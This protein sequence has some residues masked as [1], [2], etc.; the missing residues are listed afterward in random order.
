MSICDSFQEMS[1]HYWP[2]EVDG[3]QEYGKVMVKKISQEKRGD[4]IL[5]KFVVDEKKQQASSLLN[6]KTAFTVTQF[7]FLVW[8]EHETPPIT[9]SLIELVD[10][11]N[12]VQM[13]SGNRPMIVMCK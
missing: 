10:N 13:G 6:V 2:A 11:V 1:A 8:P 9:S 3:P 7:Q 4:I 5:R 12:K